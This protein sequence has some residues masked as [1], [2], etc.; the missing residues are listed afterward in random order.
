VLRVSPCDNFQNSCTFEEISRL[1]RARSSSFKRDF[2][3]SLAMNMNI[4]VCECLR[5]SR[6]VGCKACI[7]SSINSLTGYLVRRPDYLL[8]GLHLRFRL[9]PFAIHLYLSS[10]RMNASSYYYAVAMRS[11]WL[12]LEVL[13]KAF[14]TEADLTSLSGCVIA[15]SSTSRPKQQKSGFLD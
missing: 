7:Y 10:S 11:Q 8:R 13:M 5:R 2:P 3:L 12:F 9:T 1:L 15:M 14:R 6:F 4:S